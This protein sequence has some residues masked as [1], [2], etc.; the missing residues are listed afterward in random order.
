MEFQ[1]D[2]STLQGQSKDWIEAYNRIQKVEQPSIEAC[3]STDSHPQ[4]PN[5]VLYQ[6]L[7]KHNAADG[8]NGTAAGA[9]AKKAD[10]EQRRPGS[11]HF[12][13]DIFRSLLVMRRLEQAIEAGNI[14]DSTNTSYHM[15]L[16]LVEE[17]AAFKKGN[18]P[19]TSGKK[20]VKGKG[21]A[22][23]QAPSLSSDDESMA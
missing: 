7:L 1:H 4:N 13:A 23:A 14:R 6:F 22:D 8:L 15:N 5:R 16:R 2:I 21:K 9:K 11:S 18:A 12:R 10:R 19:H 20:D 3:T 17:V